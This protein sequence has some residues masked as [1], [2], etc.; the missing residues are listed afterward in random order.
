M[1]QSNGAA[2]AMRVKFLHLLLCGMLSGILVACDAPNTQKRAEETLVFNVD[3]T[4]L[5]PAIRDATLRITMA[6]P[7]EWKQI[8]DAVMLA[9][10]TEQ[11]EKQ[12]TQGLAL[13]PR[14]LFLNARSRAMCFVSAV[15]GVDI[16]PD[17]TLLQRL[18]IAY[19]D[20]FPKAQV[21]R[22]TFRKD[23]FRIHQL[24]VSTPDFVLIK[25][26]CDAPET[27]IFEVDYVVPTSVYAAELRAI[28]SSIGS[29]HVIAVP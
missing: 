12:L 17:D 15:N 3:K 20:A 13:A 8:E 14:W 23:A 19:R 16:A 1:C 27:L 4:R 11:V 24:M 28:E 5:E 18:E 22:T 21:K 9:K 7:K 25:L 6:A 26:I 29:I 10:F 2:V